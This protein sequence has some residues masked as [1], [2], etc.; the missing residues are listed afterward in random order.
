MCIFSPLCFLQVSAG[1]QGKHKLAL[2]QS[3]C[4]K[5]KTKFWLPISGDAEARCRGMNSEKVEYAWKN[6]LRQVAN[7]CLLQRS[8]ALRWSAPETGHP[9]W[10]HLSSQSH[11]PEECTLALACLPWNSALSA[12]I[13]DIGSYVCWAP[14]QILK[15]Q[16]RSKRSSF[17]CLVYCLGQHPFLR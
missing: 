5:G 16:S 1:K 3:G 11:I 2:S 9:C 10:V 14:P 8:L 7:L 12:V 17:Y 6:F 4:L 13:A 15:G